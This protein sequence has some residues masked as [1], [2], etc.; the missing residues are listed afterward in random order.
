M[1][2]I[3]I[4]YSR[5][6]SSRALSLAEK[7]RTHGI[8]IWID[9]HGIEGAS[10]WS[11]EIV[12]AINQCTGFIVLLSAASVESDNVVREVAL[13]FE[14][15]K[16]ILPIELESV[17]LP[18]PMEYP[19]A[20]I[21]KLAFDNWDAIER[22][23]AK[24]VPLREETPA[25]PPAVITLP[26]D[27]LGRKMIAVLPFEN[28]SSDPDN[29]WFAD[30]LTQELIGMLSKLSSLCVTDRR[31][32]MG[33]KNTTKPVKAIAQELGVEYVIEGTVRKAGPNLRITS[34]LVEVQSGRH[35]W[36][37]TFKGTIDDIFEIQES[38]AKNIVDGLDLIL[39]PKEKDSLL[40]Q[41]TIS[42]EA[43]EL[44]LRARELGYT[45]D[46]MKGIPLLERA[47]ELDP[48][49]IGAYSHLSSIY[50][51][52]RRHHPEL[53]DKAH[54]YAQK[55]YA[56]DPENP[57][58]NVSMGAAIFNSGKFEEA[59]QY[60]LRAYSADPNATGTN[61]WMGFYHRR[62]KNFTE[63][64]RY[65]ERALELEPGQPHFIMHLYGIYR[66]KNDVAALKDLAIRAL[67]HLELRLQ[68]NHDHEAA[69]MVFLA[70]LPY[71]GRGDQVIST[72]E[73]MD[74]KSM[75]DPFEL[76]DMACAACPVSPSYGL[77][78]LRL[79]LDRG[80]TDIETM[81][82]D[83]DLA[84]IQDTAE[85]KTMLKELEDKTTTNIG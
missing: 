4:S 16:K 54:E 51:R 40:K 39:N 31:S 82:N 24:L 68:T 46:E 47:I 21:Q 74:P 58:S 25:K 62:L 34:E 22:V 44:Y 57:T 14:K 19:L 76:Y 64:A 15:K 38:V 29:E 43:Y 45:K 10:S 23:L 71:A 73:K 52:A 5:K 8:S 37:E 65:Y 41:P 2:D 6:D 60:L 78:L 30:G 49:F 63:A 79:S 26:S 59:Y 1:A 75:T 83:P 28:L 33:Y 12:R 69:D 81:R 27:P 3:F 35:L 50:N 56:L 7:L 13:A 42:S 20:G 55:A 32:V 11:G 9:Q 85:F 18:E 17:A 77:E 36:S 84:P 70:L 67:P 53:S 72:I 48:N 80:F 66:E 61:A